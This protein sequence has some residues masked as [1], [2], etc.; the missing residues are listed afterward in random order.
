MNDCCAKPESLTEPKPHGDGMVAICK[1]CERRHFTMNAERGVIG[2]KGKQVGNSS[3]VGRLA[4]QV[5]SLGGVTLKVENIVKKKEALLA[6][7]D[8]ARVIVNRMEEA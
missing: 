7:L 8:E 1:V 3:D 4:I 5:T 6:L 2:V